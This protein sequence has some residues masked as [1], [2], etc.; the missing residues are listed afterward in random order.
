MARVIVEHNK[1]TVDARRVGSGDRVTDGALV[2]TDAKGVGTVVFEK[3]AG[4]CHL[5][6]HTQVHITTLAAAMGAPNQ[7]LCQ[8]SGG[9]GI[10]VKV[11][12]ILVT[13]ISGEVSVVATDTGAT[14]AVR[15]GSA[16]V[17][18]DNVTRLLVPA[19]GVTSF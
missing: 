4:R 13:L 11:G 5:G 12:R 19:D 8:A 15:R 7:L 18:A 17:T 3:S 1:L 10:R 14:V 6:E 9:P 16:S 2:A